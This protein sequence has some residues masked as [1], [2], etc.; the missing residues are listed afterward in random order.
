MWCESSP[1]FFIDIFLTNLD[2]YQNYKDFEIRQIGTKGLPSDAKF[3]GKTVPIYALYYKGDISKFYSELY[4]RNSAGN[5]YA[6]K[7]DNK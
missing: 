1:C 4:Y 7:S 5:S 2:N 6:D 3:A